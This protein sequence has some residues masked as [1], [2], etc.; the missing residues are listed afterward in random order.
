LVL[1]G[2]FYSVNGR[3]FNLSFSR[4]SK[5]RRTSLIVREIFGVW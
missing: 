3:A 2:G 1:P 5:L 4:R